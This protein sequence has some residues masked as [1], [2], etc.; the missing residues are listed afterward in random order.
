[1]TLKSTT[2]HMVNVSFIKRKSMSLKFKTTM[3]LFKFLLLATAIMS[4]QNE[5]TVIIE[6]QI[7]ISPDMYSLKISCVSSNVLEKPW[8]KGEKY[9]SKDSVLKILDEIEGVK[10]VANPNELIDT[11]IQEL[12]DIVHVDA[13]GTQSYQAI[14]KKLFMRAV[15]LLEEIHIELFEQ[16]ESNLIEKLIDDAKL[17]V[18]QELEKYGKKVKKVLNFKEVKENI[19]EA[20]TGI[21]KETYSGFTVLKAKFIE[22]HNQGHPINDMGQIVMKKKIEVKFEIE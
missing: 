12:L 7:L 22:Y 3:L 11:S 20:N 8:M 18:N 1:M 15:V 14:K 16:H 10:I 4:G 2:S 17:M 5:Y 21:E 6:D 13:I 19:E 9:I